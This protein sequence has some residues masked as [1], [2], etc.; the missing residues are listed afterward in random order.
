MRI[1]LCGDVMTG[2]GIDQ[3]LSYPCDPH[4]HETYVKSA[5]RYRELAERA[6]GPIPAPLDFAVIWGAALDEWTR[7]RPD[8]RIVNLETSITRNDSYVRK[9]IN[10]RMSPENA[11]CLAMAGVDCCVLANNHSLD[12]ERQGLL[13]TL[14]TLERLRIKTAGA[15]RNAG[16]ASVPAVLTSGAM[17][18]VLVFSYASSTAGVPRDWAATEEFAGV[19]LLP[20]LSDATAAAIAGQVAAVR[21]AGDIVVISLHWGPN[22]GYD[23]TDEE[24]TFAHA[25]IDKAGA[26]IIHGHSSHHPKTIE[27]YRNR[28]ILYGCGDFLNDYEGIRGHEHYRPDLVLMYFA[29]LDPA[30]LDLVALDLVPLGIRR[31]QLVRAASADIAWLGETLDRHSRPFGSRIGS[32]PGGRLT[33]S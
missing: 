22:W 21:Q 8:L 16:E 24:R 20:S 29:D 9:G 11:R 7:A 32:A 2:R 33:L 15:G 26:S 3:A 1:F 18:R 19:N 31:F 23:V 6:N 12:W 14:A 13:D 4:L 27:V 28:L 5:V 17:G 25:L 30:S 10:Y